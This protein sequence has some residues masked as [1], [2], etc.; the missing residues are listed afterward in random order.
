MTDVS[1]GDP[2]YADGD[3]IPYTLGSDS[4]VAG[5]A[6]T[7][8]T[9]SGDLILADGTNGWVGILGTQTSASSEEIPGT[10]ASGDEVVLRCHGPVRANVGDSV[11]AGARLSPGT[12]GELTAATTTTPNPGDAWA[13]TDADSD[14]FA[15]VMIP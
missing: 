3:S 5:D 13:I 14:G 8:S 9:T 2:R 11:T 1:P 7:I 15:Y 4:A 6:V 10:I 12:G